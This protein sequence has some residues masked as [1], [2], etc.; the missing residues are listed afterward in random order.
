MYYN[1]FK[2]VPWNLTCAEIVVLM[3]IAPE[4]TSESVLCFPSYLLHVLN[5]Y[6]A[7]NVYVGLPFSS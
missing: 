5:V 7:H 3:S 1:G 4:T 6:N 2:L